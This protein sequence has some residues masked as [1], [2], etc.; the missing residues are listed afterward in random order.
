[1]VRVQKL[2]G[3]PGKRKPPRVN[4]GGFF[5]AR[6]L[7]TSDNQVGTP[8]G[9]ERV[10][11][12]NGELLDFLQVLILVIFSVGFVAE[13]QDERLVVRGVRENPAPERTAPEVLRPLVEAA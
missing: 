5:W 6:R 3:K 4:L 2:S 8:E 1:M 11:W 12:V 10:E 13:A 9:R 7:R